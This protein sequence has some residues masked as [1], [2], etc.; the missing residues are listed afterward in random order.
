MKN[1]FTNYILPDYKEWTTNKLIENDEVNKKIFERL[2]FFVKSS[3]RIGQRLKKQR[4]AGLKKRK[5][6]YRIHNP[7]PDDVT[8][9]FLLKLFVEVN[10]KKVE[11]IVREEALFA[12]MS[13]RYIAGG[14]EEGKVLLSE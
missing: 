7:N 1:N 5:L 13:D 9:D 4:G 10:A 11:R 6:N 3:H 2:V 8:A 14:N 12:E